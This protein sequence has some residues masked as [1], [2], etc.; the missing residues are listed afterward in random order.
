MGSMGRLSLIIATL[1]PRLIGL[2]VGPAAFRGHG[3][4][5]LSGWQHDEV[6]NEPAMI[7][8]WLGY[9]RSMI[10]LGYCIDGFVGFDRAVRKALNVHVHIDEAGHQGAPLQINR[11]HGLPVLKNIGTAEDS[12]FTIF[13]CGPTDRGVLVDGHGFAFDEQQSS[14]AWAASAGSRIA[15]RA[16]TSRLA[17]FMVDLSGEDD[18]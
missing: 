14:W 16:M 7:G 8:V 17:G 15:A 1:M 18:A 5:R 12:D 3:L 6:R 10:C 9:Q 11:A 2:R 4:H 13:D